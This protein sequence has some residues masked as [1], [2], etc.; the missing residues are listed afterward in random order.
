L[1][2]TSKGL[3]YYPLFLTISC[4]ALSGFHATQS[5]IISRTINNEKMV[6]NTLQMMILEA[7]IAMIWAAAAMSLMNGE[8]S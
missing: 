4:G 6:E 3:P 5:P 1:K 7:V 2:F 8:R